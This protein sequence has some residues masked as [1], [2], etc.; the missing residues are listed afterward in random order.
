[1]GQGGEGGER[2]GLGGEQVPSGQVANDEPANYLVQSPFKH[3]RWPV[4]VCLS[5]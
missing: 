3:A 2:K 4:V 5:S 1:M